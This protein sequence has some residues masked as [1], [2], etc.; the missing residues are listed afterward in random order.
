MAVRDPTAV[1]SP[2]RHRR[3]I[4]APGSQLHTL[5]L[6]QATQQQQQQQQ[7]V[8]SNLAG[9]LGSGDLGDDSDAQRHYSSSLAERVA[10][11][12][13]YTNLPLDVLSVDA[14]QVPG[15][16]CD[17]PDSN[18]SAFSVVSQPGSL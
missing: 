2:S 14:G 6:Q 5:A 3:T 8:L 15:I 13:S 18:C 11:N 12:P 9:G 17:T 10:G 16:S 1:E 7:Q 4:S